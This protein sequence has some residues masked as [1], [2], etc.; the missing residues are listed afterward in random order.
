MARLYT[1]KELLKKFKNKYI[2]VRFHNYE[3]RDKYGNWITLYEVIGV[4]KTLKEDYEP[5]EEAI[6]SS[7]FVSKYI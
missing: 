4:S 1:E 2:K 5:P 7:I 3:K 6:D